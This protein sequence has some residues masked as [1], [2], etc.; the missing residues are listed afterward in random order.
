MNDIV[1]ATSEQTTI[2][3]DIKSKFEILDALFHPV[4]NLIALGLINGKVKM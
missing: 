3:P 4:E 2:H 1:N